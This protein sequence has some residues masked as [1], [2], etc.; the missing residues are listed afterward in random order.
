MADIIKKAKDV[1]A[2][3]ADDIKSKLNELRR[4]LFDLRSQAVT[5]NLKDP[6]ELGKA[7]KAIARMM[8]ILAEKTAAG[9]KRPKKLSRELRLENAALTREAKAKAAAKPAA[10]SRRQQRLAA[11]RAKTGGAPARS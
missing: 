1:R 4:H 7:R 9:A 3:S 5:E 2:L 6:S 10:A 8:T 11:K